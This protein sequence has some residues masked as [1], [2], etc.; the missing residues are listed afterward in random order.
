MGIR[1]TGAALMANSA[2]ILQVPAAFKAEPK[3]MGS[4]METVASRDLLA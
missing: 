2:L 3:D 4:S 1:M